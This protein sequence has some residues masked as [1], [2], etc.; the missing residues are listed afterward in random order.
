MGIDSLLIIGFPK[1]CR[2]LQSTWEVVTKFIRK[3]AKT[4]R[5][6]PNNTRGVMYSVVHMPGALLTCMGDVLFTCVCIHV[7]ALSRRFFY[8]ALRVWVLR[9]SAGVLLESVI[10]FGRDGIVLR[11]PRTVSHL[12]DT[13]T[14]GLL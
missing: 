14:G 11:L 1:L 12:A 6:L 4:D 3:Q 2:T 7:P 9:N 5:F 8:T 13:T 10:M